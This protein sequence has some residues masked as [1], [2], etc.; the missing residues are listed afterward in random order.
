[1][2][3]WSVSANPGWGILRTLLFRTT[4]EGT[5][6]WTTINHLD[7]NV[8]TDTQHDGLAVRVPGPQRRGAGGSARVAGPL[9]RVFGAAGGVAGGGDA[10][11]AD[12]CVDGGTDTGAAGRW[13]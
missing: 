6:V 3:P 12:G 8:Y 2:G 9:R 11:G 10:G 7:N 1:M 5:A 13:W 4:D